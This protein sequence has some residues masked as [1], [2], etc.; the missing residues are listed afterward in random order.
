MKTIIATRVFLVALLVLA[1]GS[2]SQAG[3]LGQWTFEPGE[4]LI[5]KQ[6]NWQPLQLAGNAAVLGSGELDVNG[7]GT[8]S[9]GWAGTPN[10]TGYSGPQ[11]VDHT[12]VS[13]ATMQSLAPPNAGSILTIDRAGDHF[14][15]IV[16]G[17][18][19]A[20]RWMAG[21][22]FFDRSGTPGDFAGAGAVEGTTGQVIQMAISYDDQDNVPGGNMTVTG[23]RNGVNIGSYVSGNGSSWNT[24]D[25]EILFGIRHGNIG[26]GPGGIDALIEEAH[27]YDMVLTQQEIQNLQIF[28]AGQ[29]GPSPGPQPGPQP[30]PAPGPGG[31]AAPEP[32]ALAL[33]VLALMGIHA[34][35]WRRRRRK[36]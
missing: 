2:V 27:I 18:R 17:E 16:F 8:N 9:T 21:S 25:A 5:D 10:A 12:L 33:A 24:G 32:S 4:E 36:T 1:F 20:N 6:S 7:A 3:L 22:S 15:G 14:D 31:A 34:S 11:I 30:G 13:W 29:P 26:G 23:Y 19:S 35:T 28:K